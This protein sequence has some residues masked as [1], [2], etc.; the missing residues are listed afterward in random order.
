MPAGLPWTFCNVTAKSYA[1]WF[2]LG[3]GATLLGNAID[4]NEK[5]RCSKF[6]DQ[7]K[8]FGGNRKEGE[9]PSWGNEYKSWV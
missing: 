3:T 9:A 7:S 8:M 5:D 4:R 6:R 1:V 2:A